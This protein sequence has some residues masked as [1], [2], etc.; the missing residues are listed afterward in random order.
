MYGYKTKFSVLSNGTAIGHTHSWSGS[1]A[2]IEIFKENIAWHLTVTP[3]TSTEEHFTDKGEVSAKYDSN[4]AILVE[5][6]STGL[7][8]L[9]R[10]IGLSKKL[11]NGW[12]SVA[13]RT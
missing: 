4:L 2:Y 9:L 13:K 3:K 10:I 1:H 8:D 5:K 11:K 12:L 7:A 6:G